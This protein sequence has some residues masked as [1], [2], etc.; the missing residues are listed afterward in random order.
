MSGIQQDKPKKRKQLGPAPI[1]SFEDPLE[2]SNQRVNRH[3]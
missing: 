1:A 2:A 3:T